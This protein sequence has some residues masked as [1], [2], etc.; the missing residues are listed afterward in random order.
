MPESIERAA[1][2][3][4]PSA[5]KLPS[6]PELPEEATAILGIVAEL[7]SRYSP[8]GLAASVGR[9]RV[10]LAGWIIDRRLGADAEPDEET[11]KLAISDLCERELIRITDSRRMEATEAGAELWQTLK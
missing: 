1:G 7:P 6:K 5:E 11:V 8:D 10:G 2:T 9:T 3:V 4:L